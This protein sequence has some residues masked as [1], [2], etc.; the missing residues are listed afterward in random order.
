MSWPELP[1]KCIDC[2]YDDKR[3]ICDPL[4]GGLSEQPRK[5]LCPRC[6]ATILN[7]HPK[8]LQRH[9]AVCNVDPDLAPEPPAAAMS[10]E[11]DL[12]D[13][14][15]GEND[16][17]HTIQSLR[18]KLESAEAENARLRVYELAAKRNAE[19]W[20]RERNERDALR[21]ELAS[22]TE[23]RDLWK[24]SEATC[25]ALYTK[26]HDECTAL[27]SE[28]AE[29]RAETAEVKRVSSN[30]VDSLLR[31]LIPRLT[32]DELEELKRRAA[33]AVGEP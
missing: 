31:S 21:S 25:D 5:L 10:E 23:D 17:W 8:N 19:A 16:E 7:G 11:D 15:G 27:R 13:L 3:C 30:F 32:W 6:R 26:L 18:S 1:H 33:A 24:Q 12:S 20:E 14:E 28:L 29:A 2:G 9:L 22:V 4:E